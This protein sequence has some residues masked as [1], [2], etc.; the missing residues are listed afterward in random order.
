MS[1]INP[2]HTFLPS[3]SQIH[4]YIILPSIKKLRGPSLCSQQPTICPEPDKSNPHLPTLLSDPLIY[5]PPNRD[6]K[7]SPPCQKSL[8]FMFCSVL[9]AAFHSSHSALY[10][11]SYQQNCHMVAAHKNERMQGYNCPQTSIHANSDAMSL[12]QQSNSHATKKK[13]STQPKVQ[14]HRIMKNYK[15][16]GIPTTR[17]LKYPTRNWSVSQKNTTWKTRYEDSILL[18]CV[19][20]SLKCQEPPMQQHSV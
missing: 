7:S 4:S 18:V 14:L 3:F 9:S 13:S 6:T 20:K 12:F 5:Y 17:C 8:L 10:S 16:P 1:Q 11:A 15:L 2:I 19:Y